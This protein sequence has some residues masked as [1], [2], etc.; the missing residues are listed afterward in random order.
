MNKNG[1]ISDAEN[2]TST[3]TST[4]LKWKHTKSRRTNKAPMSLTMTPAE[5][6]EIREDTCLKLNV[7]FEKQCQNYTT[8]EQESFW[9]MNPCQNIEISIFNA[10]ICKSTD[11]NLP[12]K[13]NSNRF[14]TMYELKKEDVLLNID[15][16]SIIGSNYI[17]ESLI[18]KR[19]LPHEIGFLRPQDLCPE[20]WATIILEAGNHRRQKIQQAFSSEFKCPRCKQW[21]STYTEVQTRSADEPMTIFATCVNPQC[22][23]QWRM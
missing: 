9:K 19:L 18:Q 23:H 11:K 3:K 13:W 15:L 16:S 7:I 12:R 22:K 6:Q 1:T 10:I 5:I 4:S 20:R 8:E 17:F 14:K 2:L 21:K